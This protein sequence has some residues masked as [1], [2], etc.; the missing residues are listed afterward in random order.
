MPDIPKPVCQ[1]SCIQVLNSSKVG[2]ASR[3]LMDYKE[4][5]LL[6]AG[7]R[8]LKSHVGRMENF[9]ICVYVTTCMYEPKETPESDLHH[10]MILF[11]I[12]SL[13]L[14]IRQCLCM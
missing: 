14:H 7:A 3:S 11:V 2:C 12:K 10:S 6:R 8:L 13:S 1:S 4:K 5:K 9:I